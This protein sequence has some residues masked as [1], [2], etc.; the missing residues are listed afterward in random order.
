MA[1][2]FKQFPELTAKQLEEMPFDSPHKQITED[3]YALVVKVHDGDTITLR[4]EFRDFDFPLRFLGI[5]AKELNEGG[6]EARDWM[7]ERLLNKEIWV[8]IDP[9]NKVDKWGRLLGNVFQGGFDVGEEEMNL[10]LATT[11]D[12][13]NEGKIIN[14][15]KVF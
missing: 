13:R 6:E 11:Y 10:G 8:E 1:H 14:P 9:D 5:D 15:I 4:T 3:F 7:T 2:D 12:D